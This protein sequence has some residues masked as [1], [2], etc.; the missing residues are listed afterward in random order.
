MSN[1]PWKDP[2]LGTGKSHF[3]RNTCSRPYT[4]GGVEAT[5]GIQLYN[6]LAPSEIHELRYPK[7]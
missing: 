4:L 7:E 3:V 2:S 1:L 5:P 6:L